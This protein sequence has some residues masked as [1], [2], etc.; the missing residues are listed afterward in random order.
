VWAFTEKQG[1]IKRPVGD[2]G[3]RKKPIKLNKNPKISTT[4]K[5]NW[6]KKKE[7]EGNPLT[8]MG[9]ILRKETETLRGKVQPLPGWFEKGGGICLHLS[10][11]GQVSWGK[12]GRLK[13]PQKKCMKHMG[14]GGG[15]NRRGGVVKKGGG[16][17]IST[18]T[19]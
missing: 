10:K 16:P 3:K 2:E 1:K 17:C 4:P 11:G 15:K 18:K 5:L 14:K 12:E 6:A 9:E 13:R 19:L 8:G 7:K